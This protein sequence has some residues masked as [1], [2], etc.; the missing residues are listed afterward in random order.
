MI[1]PRIAVFCDYEQILHIFCKFLRQKMLRHIKKV[2][3][4][5]ELK[6]QIMLRNNLVKNTILSRFFSFQYIKL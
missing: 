6:S 1:C 4:V 3:I 5:N 2:L